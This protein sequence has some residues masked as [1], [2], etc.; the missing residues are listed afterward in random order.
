MRSL[1]VFYRRVHARKQYRD[2]SQIQTGNSVF[3]QKAGRT[4][5]RGRMQKL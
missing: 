5:H 2:K 4:E 3:C 1:Q